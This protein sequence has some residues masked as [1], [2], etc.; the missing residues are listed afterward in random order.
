M[1]LQT[2][3]YNSSLL[4][5][6]RILWNMNCFY[7]FLLARP[8]FFRPLGMTT[9][10]AGFECYVLFHRSELQFLTCLRPCYPFLAF[11]EAD[12]CLRDAVQP[13][14]PWL[15]LCAWAVNSLASTLEIGAWCSVARRAISECSERKD[16]THKRPAER[17]IG[18]DDCSWDFPNIPVQKNWAIGDSEVVVTV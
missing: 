6:C 8:V 13:P 2:L 10:D 17:D 14:A 3:C 16:L 1:T 11:A 5:L 12:V 4:S 15:I 18:H 7:D 9:C